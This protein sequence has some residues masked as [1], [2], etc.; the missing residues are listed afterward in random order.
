MSL[1]NTS[2]EK[3]NHQELKHFIEQYILQSNSHSSNDRTNQG[4]S[5]SAEHIKEYGSAIRESFEELKNQSQ[6]SS[7]AT[8]KLIEEA[9]KAKN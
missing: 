9:E 2:L 3:L 4:K 8:W 6:S 1:S 7:L 5:F